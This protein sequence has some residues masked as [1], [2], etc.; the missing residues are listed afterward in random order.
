MCASS[1]R[2][3]GA[4]DAGMGRRPACSPLEFAPISA[5]G[6]IASEA[7]DKEHAAGAKTRSQHVPLAE[8]AQATALPVHRAGTVPELVT[9]ID[10]AGRTGF[11]W[12]QSAPML[13][14]AGSCIEHRHGDLDIAGAVLSDEPT[15]DDGLVA[16]ASARARCP[17]SSE[18]ALRSLGC[19]WRFYRPVGYDLRNRWPACRARQ[20][21]TMASGAGRR[22][23][24]RSRPARRAQAT[25]TR[26]GLGHRRPIG[27]AG[28]GTVAAADWWRWSCRAWPMMAGSDGGSESAVD[29]E[30]SAERD[31]GGARQW[32]AA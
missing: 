5:G 17:G 22:G 28:C 16:A 15:C 20:A 27:R 3:D 7:S 12:M 2:G 31:R 9:R 18:A 24:R 6:A 13:R 1:K 8:P 14:M 30:V 19:R 25:G 26:R 4:R 21:G 11:I 23:R 32:R 10:V 29:A